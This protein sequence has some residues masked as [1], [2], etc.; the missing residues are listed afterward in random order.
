MHGAVLLHKLAAQLPVL[1]GVE[2][3]V[4]VV[5]D[6]PLGEVQQGSQ[7]AQSA[8]VCLHLGG[9]V[10]GSKKGPVAVGSDI[11]SLVNNVQKARLQDLE[12]R[13]KGKN[14]ERLLISE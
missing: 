9:V 5:V 3:A 7:L 2:L 13:K 1:Q 10:V 4:V 14:K 11:A 12:D 6:E 8:A